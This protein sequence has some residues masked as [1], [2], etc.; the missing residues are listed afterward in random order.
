MTRWRSK[1]VERRKRER[2]EANREEGENRRPKPKEKRERNRS[3]H[4]REAQKW[5]GLEMLSNEEKVAEVRTLEVSGRTTGIGF[6]RI[7]SSPFCFI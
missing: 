2:G 7:P 1:G 5:A 4:P 3:E 6:F